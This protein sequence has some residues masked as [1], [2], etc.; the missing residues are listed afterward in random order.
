MNKA[1]FLDRDGTLNE[2]YDFVHKP[3]EWTWCKGAVEAI[4]WMNKNGYKVIVV[5]NQS[6][7]ARGRFSLEQVHELHRFVDSKLKKVGAWI[8]DWCIAHW[9]SKFHEGL[10]E[11]LLEY[12]KPG[13]RY[14]TE[15]ISKYDLK[16]S[17]CFM[18]GDKPSDLQPALELGMKAFYIKSRFHEKNDPTFLEKHGLKVFDSIGDVMKSNFTKTN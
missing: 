10:D 4:Q 7:V 2:D 9:H 6:G 1:F 15:I 16:P 17:D 5:T 18:M 8:D 12:R 3:E 14:F 13:T 11:K